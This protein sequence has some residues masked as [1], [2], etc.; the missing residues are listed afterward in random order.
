MSKHPWVGKH[1]QLDDQWWRVDCV[2]ES[3][4][5]V[6]KGGKVRIVPRSMLDGVTLR[7]GVELREAEMEMQHA[8]HAADY[9][10]RTGKQL[11]PEAAW[12][13][14]SKPADFFAPSYD[15]TWQF[16]REQLDA[17]LITVD[18]CKVLMSLY[19][20]EHLRDA[21]PLEREM[22]VGDVKALIAQRRQR[23]SYERLEAREAAKDA[24]AE[25]TPQVI[26]H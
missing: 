22:M 24:A 9:F 16:M 1:I 13:S 5:D 20:H 23:E 3:D 4:I 19:G 18:D 8:K 11:G 14:G 25:E 7:T 2:H 26:V 12:D 21:T 15:R 17:G 10:R 6:S